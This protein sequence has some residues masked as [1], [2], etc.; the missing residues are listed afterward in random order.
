MDL[1]LQKL[2]SLLKQAIQNFGAVDQYEN[3]RCCTDILRKI[4]Q[5][6][7]SES[8]FK[9][10]DELLGGGRTKP[11]RV[12]ES[13]QNNNV[14]N[15]NAAFIATSGGDILL[16]PPKPVSVAFVKSEDMSGDTNSSNN[17]PDDWKAEKAVCA[18]WKTLKVQNGSSMYFLFAGFDGKMRFT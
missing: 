14:V 8:E 1:F 12:V 3:E 4:K 16:A 18:V 13:Q 11:S 5:D 10:F 7:F 17:V 6:F 9:E 15:S 2:K